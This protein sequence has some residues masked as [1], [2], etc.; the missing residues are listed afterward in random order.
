[1]RCVGGKCGISDAEMGGKCGIL[2]LLGRG[3]LALFGC[4]ILALLI[5]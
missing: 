1:M 4:G 3:F 5:A 2:A